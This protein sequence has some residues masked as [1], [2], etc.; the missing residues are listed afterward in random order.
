MRIVPLAI[1]LCGVS[2]PAM[3]QDV[4]AVTQASQKFIAAMGGADV[5]SA[6]A[7][8]MDD[9]SVLPPGRGEMTGKPQIQMFLGN[10]TRNVQNLQ[11]TSESI[12]PVGDTGAREIGSFSFKTKGRN[13]ESA[14][15]VTGKYLIVWAKAGG[16]WKIAVDMWNRSGGQQGQG[17]KKGK[18]AGSQTGD[19]SNE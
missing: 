6:S 3:A 11:Y 4:S 5:A 2:L 15:D 18:T 19:V 16:D 10:M 13:G 17:G 9:A 7:M 8:F 14:K 1:L 12:K